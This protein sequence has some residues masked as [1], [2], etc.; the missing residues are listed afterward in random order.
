MI[1]ER[2]RP[3]C[4]KLDDRSRPTIG[5]VRGAGPPAPTS[6]H[7]S[8]DQDGEVSRPEYSAHS[9]FGRTMLSSELS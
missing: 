7:L 4:T 8:L 2:L 5:A 1:L 3:D 6:G 9:C